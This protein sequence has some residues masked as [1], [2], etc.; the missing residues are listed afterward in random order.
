MIYSNTETFGLIDS[1]NET[2]SY[3]MDI[4]E[5]TI[6]KITDLNNLRLS[7]CNVEHSSRSGILKEF[8][9]IS[10]RLYIE[11]SKYYIQFTIAGNEQDAIEIEKNFETII[12]PVDLNIFVHK[13][14]INI[15]AKVIL[16]FSEKIQSIFSGE[17]SFTIKFSQIKVRNNHSFIIQPLYMT[18]P[19]YIKNNEFLT[20][21]SQNNVSNIEGY[22]IFNIINCI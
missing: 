7:L 8:Q 4:S 10:F 16:T 21:P 6:M 18:Y 20:V 1:N 17:P 19:F 22:L 11:N 12:I 2:V 5:D 14:D 13:K 15:T 3:T 9:N